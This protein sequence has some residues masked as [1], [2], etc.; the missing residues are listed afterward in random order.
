MVLEARSLRAW[1]W[2]LAAAFLLHH[3]HVGGGRA[4]KQMEE[5]KR[6]RREPLRALVMY[7]LPIKPHLPTPLHWRL[8]SNT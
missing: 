8:S 3:N 5:V 2:P 6:A 7:P 1:C 4:G